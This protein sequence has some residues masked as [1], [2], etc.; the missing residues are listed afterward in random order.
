MVSLQ[1]AA[2]STFHCHQPKCRPVRNKVIVFLLFHT[3]NDLLTYVDLKCSSKNSVL[4]FL[5]NSI[6]VSVYLLH[7]QTMHN[8]VMHCCVTVV[9]MNCLDFSLARGY[10]L[11]SHLWHQNGFCICGVVFSITF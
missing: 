1:H 8:C 10:G 11:E 3:V 2:G 5:T 7:N 4:L 9:L 6:A